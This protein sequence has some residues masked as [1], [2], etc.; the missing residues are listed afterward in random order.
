MKKLIVRLISIFIFDKEKR[1]AFRKKHEKKK[2]TNEQILSQLKKMNKALKN[3]EFKQNL[4]LDYYLDV[5][6]IKM[7]GGAQRER[8][9]ENLVLLKE[10]IRLCEKFNLRYWLDYGSLL[11]AKRHGFTIPWDDDLDVSMPAEE[12]DK[13]EELIKNDIADNIEYIHVWNDWQSRLVFK[14]DTGAFLDIYAYNEYEDRLQGRPKFRPK[15]ASDD[16]K[17]HS[18]TAR[19]YSFSSVFQHA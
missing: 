12:F 10:F 6:S 4:Y 19:Q 8:Q 11:G 13:F 9:E 3:I 5:S 15:A 2:I 1:K 7:A 14:N 17:R 16:G 18:K